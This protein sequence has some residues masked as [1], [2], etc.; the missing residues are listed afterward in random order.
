MYG[1]GGL[2]GGNSLL[3]GEIKRSS[4]LDESSSDAKG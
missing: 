3:R 2:P 4:S 1:G